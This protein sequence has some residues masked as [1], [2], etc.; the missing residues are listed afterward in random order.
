MFHIL[1]S[2]FLSE[3]LVSYGFLNHRLL[4]YNY[5]PFVSYAGDCVLR[6]I[7]KT[8]SIFREHTIDEFAHLL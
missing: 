3:Y 2:N 5:S 4:N 6:I 8:N 7:D 1:T